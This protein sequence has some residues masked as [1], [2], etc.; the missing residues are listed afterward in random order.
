MYR[1]L[2]RSAVCKEFSYH[3]VANQFLTRE[4]YFQ[5]T[6]NTSQRSV[7]FEQLIIKHVIFL[8]S[9]LIELYKIYLEEILWFNILYGIEKFRTYLYNV[10]IYY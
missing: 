5:I 2:L 8:T 6:F 1:K 9:L 7:Y 3:M 10:I 4:I